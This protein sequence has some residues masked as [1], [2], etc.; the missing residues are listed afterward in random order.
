LAVAR[1]QAEKAA[2]E[3][4]QDLDDA[5]LTAKEERLDPEVPLHHKP[6]GLAAPMPSGEQ[7]PAP[8]TPPPGSPEAALLDGAL[9]TP[10][11]TPRAERELPPQ[12]TAP[13]W[14]HGAGAYHPDVESPPPVDLAAW[15]QQDYGQMSTVSRPPV[16][17]WGKLITGIILLDVGVLIFGLGMTIWGLVIPEHLAGIAASPLTGEISEIIILA[18]T[19]AQ[20]YVGGYLMLS[21]IGMFG[22][23]AALITT[24]FH[25][26]SL[27][28]KGEQ[29]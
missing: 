9:L 24:S 22:G 5:T 29:P 2:A 3:A 26:S 4:Q 14:D 16:V 25:P 8:Y 12:H 10:G 27:R 7:P 21:G 20:I 15:K 23:G 28:G 19:P 17:E 11:K 6:P 18:D 13:P 1:D